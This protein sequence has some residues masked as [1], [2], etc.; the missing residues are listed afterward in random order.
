MT[1]AEHAVQG[2]DRSAIQWS[3]V[4]GTSTRPLLGMTIGDAFDQIVAR[5]PDREAL[6]VRQQHLRYTWAELRDEVDRC[7]R[8]L[9]ALGIQKGQRVGIWAPNRA[10]WAITQFA[11]AKIGAILVNIN[12]SY[13]RHELEYAL[14]QSSCAALV[15][16]PNFRATSYIEMMQALCPELE[17]S[18]PGK[19]D[20]HSL[21]N[22]RHVIRMGEERTP[23][24]WNWGDVMAKASEVSAE[25][26]AAHQAEQEFDDPI[27]IQYTSGTTGNPKG[28]T[29][30][31]HNILNNGYF[32]A[33]LQGFTER[34]RL[35]IPVPLYHSFG[36]L[37]CF[38]THSS[39]I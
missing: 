30:S 26:L 7:A 31:H 29:L 16:S 27:N 1:Q 20:A 33:R 24:M 36:T 4:S 10:E 38:P 28:A 2:Q 39:M 14:N 19:L 8:G 12:P 11:T 34:D 23:G 18:Q 37:S 9:L 32:V 17:R 25:Q 3:Y 13:R 21:P 35:C 5:F 6:V 22:L 15:L